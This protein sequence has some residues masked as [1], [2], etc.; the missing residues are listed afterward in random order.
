MNVDCL[1]FPLL[2]VILYVCP[3]F[4]GYFEMATPSNDGGH[5]ELRG[6]KRRS[7]SPPPWQRP[8]KASRANNEVG[9]GSRRQEAY[10]TSELARREQVRLNQIQEDEKAREW[11]AQEE[12]FVLRQAKRKAEIR[13]KDGR[14]KPIDWLA[15]TLR[16]ID[17]TRNPLD[18]DF[19]DVEI[20][21][22]DPRTVFEGLSEMQL[23]ELEKDIESFLNLEKNAQNKEYW[24]VS[25]I[26][27][28]S[29]GV[30]TDPCHR[31]QK[32]SVVTV[33]RNQLLTQKAAPSAPCPPTL[34]DC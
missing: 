4:S 24:R 15:V 10:D 3:I 28:I 11:V 14:A 29:A 12:D 13:V 19:D 2:Q 20:G 34:T 33:R 26:Y 27:I 5:H 8:H 9:R 18:D 16:T 25:M 32:S 17:T 30:Y 23:L 31:V 6:V 22:V 7:H 1:I 21:I